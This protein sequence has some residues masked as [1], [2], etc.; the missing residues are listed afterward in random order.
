MKTLRSMYRRVQKALY[1]TTDGWNQFK[2][3]VEY[4]LSDI[5]NVQLEEHNNASVYNLSGQR[6]TAP[7]KGINI[8]NGR[9]VV[10]K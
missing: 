9:K 4:D 1:E 5:R 6:L 7:R 2:N 8:I 10:V 3:I